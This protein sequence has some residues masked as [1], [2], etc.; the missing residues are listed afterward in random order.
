MG[1]AVP[2]KKSSDF[3]RPLLTWPGR[4]FC[5]MSWQAGNSIASGIVLSNFKFN[6]WGLF[7]SFGKRGSGEYAA[8]P[9]TRLAVWGF[10]NHLKAFLPLHWV[11]DDVHSQGTKSFPRCINALAGR[12]RS[13]RR[14]QGPQLPGWELFCVRLLCSRANCQ[15]GSS[16]SNLVNASP[17]PKY[18][19]NH[20]AEADGLHHPQTHECPRPEK[21]GLLR[22][23]VAQ[24]YPSRLLLSPGD[25][26]S[27]FGVRVTR[28]GLSRITHCR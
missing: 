8:V 18:P 6:F 13:R 20:I 21:A 12:G 25:H 3:C 1:Q 4:Q 23:I 26:A 10:P 9:A 16:S 5:A 24:V 17:P 19:A 14:D 15:D 28:Y 7:F 22:F 11:A 27:V 2:K